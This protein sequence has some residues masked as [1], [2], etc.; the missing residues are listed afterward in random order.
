MVE[1]QH[2]VGGAKGAVNPLISGFFTRHTRRFQQQ[3]RRRDARVSFFIQRNKGRRRHGRSTADLFF[4]TD[5]TVGVGGG[6][7]EEVTHFYKE[8][9]PCLREEVRFVSGRACSRVKSPA[10]RKDVRQCLKPQNEL[11]ET[12]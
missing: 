5:E 1:A 10:E 12:S 7:G 2:P 4:T 11:K 6:R 9:R 8:S 3:R